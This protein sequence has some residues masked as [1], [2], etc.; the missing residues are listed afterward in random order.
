MRNSLSHS[1][2]PLWAQLLKLAAYAL[3][4]VIGAAFLALAMASM[5]PEWGS[6]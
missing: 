5:M 1:P 2:A 3:A 6:K 4:L